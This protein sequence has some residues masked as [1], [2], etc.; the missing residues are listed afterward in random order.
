MVATLVGY[1]SVKE[2]PWHNT[3]V[4]GDNACRHWLRSSQQ[5][6]YSVGLQAPLKAPTWATIMT[7]AMPSALALAND[8]LIHL[9]SG[10]Q[11]TLVST[12]STWRQRTNRLKCR[13][14]Q[15]ACAIVCRSA[16][17][18]V[19]N[20][21]PLMLSICRLDAWEP[22]GHVTVCK[23]CTDQSMT[24]VL[25]G[26]HATTLSPAYLRLAALRTV[27]SCTSGYWS[28]RLLQLPGMLRVTYITFLYTHL[29]H[30]WDRRIVQNW[31]WYRV[32]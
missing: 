18:S 19:K 17:C 4:P 1:H 26:I 12:R 11:A 24:A 2:Q 8:S 28:H 6:S 21:Q 25:I 30:K 5:L 31:V 16:S 32:T 23:V 13:L 10:S 20:L 3:R 27:Y 15:L 14:Q 9:Q 7:P 22:T 29:Q